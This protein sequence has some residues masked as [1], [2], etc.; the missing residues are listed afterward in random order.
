VTIQEH[1]IENIYLNTSAGFL[2]P[3]IYEDHCSLTVAGTIGK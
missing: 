2:H 3:F 1:I